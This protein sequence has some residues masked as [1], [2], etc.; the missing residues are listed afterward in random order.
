VLLSKLRY[1]FG[2]GLLAEDCYR[3]IARHKVYEQRDQGYDRPDDQQ[4]NGY[5]TQCAEQLVFHLNETR[6]ALS[7]FL[8]F[9]VPLNNNKLK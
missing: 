9:E 8:K 1:L 6:K 2:R 5:A 7:L 3:R 4:Q